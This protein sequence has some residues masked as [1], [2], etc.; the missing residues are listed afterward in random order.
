MSNVQ[1]A[2]RG[3]F[4]VLFAEMELRQVFE[5]ADTQFGGVGVPQ[6]VRVL[7][8]A[9]KINCGTYRSLIKQL[10]SNFRIVLVFVDLQA[11]V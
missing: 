2:L 9:K 3:V 5:P 8:K 11:V 10:R 7:D 6:L 4:V 1:L